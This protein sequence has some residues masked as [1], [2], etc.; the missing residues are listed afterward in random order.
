MGERERGRLE[1]KD[2]GRT[3]SK[4]IKKQKKKKTS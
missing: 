1:M 3:K 4:G 2:K